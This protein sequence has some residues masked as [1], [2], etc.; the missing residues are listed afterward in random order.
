MQFLVNVDRVPNFTAIAIYEVINPE[1]PKYDSEYFFDDVGKFSFLHELSLACRLRNN[2]TNSG[3]LSFVAFAGHNQDRLNM[4]F[5][6]QQKHASSGLL[7][8]LINS[9][10]VRQ[11]R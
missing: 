5:P 9:E 3:G 6:D 7:S 11:A 10:G 8:D 4:S 2:R 1:L